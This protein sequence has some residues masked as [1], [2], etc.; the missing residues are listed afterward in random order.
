MSVCCV[1]VANHVKLKINWYN[2]NNRSMYNMYIGILHSIK[3]TL[4]S[5]SRHGSY[6][7]IMVDGVGVRVWPVKFVV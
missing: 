2:N 1:S 7:N 4:C 5:P 6:N 3:M